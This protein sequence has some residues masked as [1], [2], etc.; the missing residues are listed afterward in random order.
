MTAFLP[1]HLVMVD[2]PGKQLDA[3][4]AD[5]LREHQIRAVCLFRKNLGS[6]DEIRAL[7]SDLRAVMGERALIGIDQEGGS[8]I[9][10][11][12]VPQAPAAMAL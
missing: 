2:I 5:F 1:G 4:T 10:A 9:R 8:V 12:S 3:A 6:E 11:T 7:T